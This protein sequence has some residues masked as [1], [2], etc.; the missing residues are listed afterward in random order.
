MKCQEGEIKRGAQHVSVLRH[1]GSP[2]HS[3]E[4]TLP[5][6]LSVWKCVPRMRVYELVLKKRLLQVLW[7]NFQRQAAMTRILSQATER[8]HLGGKPLVVEWAETGSDRDCWR[9]DGCVGFAAAIIR[10]FVFNKPFF[11]HSFV[12]F[13]VRQSPGIPRSSSRQAAQS[14]ATCRNQKLNGNGGPRSRMYGANTSI[15]SEQ[16]D[17]LKYYQRGWI[18]KVDLFQCYHV[19][20]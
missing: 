2:L 13:F 19:R 4:V 7:L 14:A 5:D 9:H 8:G 11:L 1:I 10:C 6:E 18:S 15:V 12:C 20:G 17:N 3:L 16:R